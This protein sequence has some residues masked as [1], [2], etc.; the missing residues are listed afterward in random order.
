MNISEKS[1]RLI[2]GAWYSLAL[3]VAVG[4]ASYAVA[5]PMPTNGMCCKMVKCYDD[6][7]SIDCIDPCNTNEVC[8]GSGSAGSNN[9]ND[10][11]YAEADCVP[12][13]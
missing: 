11:C 13:P 3:G 1:C 2:R 8:S 6:T 12:R 4:T 9:P 10:P 5:P 7:Y